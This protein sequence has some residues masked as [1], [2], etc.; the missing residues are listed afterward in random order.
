M[1][2]N[3]KEITPREFKVGDVV[4]DSV[5]FGKGKVVNIDKQSA[6]PVDVVAVNDKHEEIF[7]YTIEGKY[8]SDD[9][10]PSLYHQPYKIELLDIPEELPEVGTPVYVWDDGDKSCTVEF[11]VEKRDKAYITSTR[12][13]IVNDIGSSW[14]NM[15]LILP[16]K[17]K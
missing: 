15:S 5:R 12:F 10:L 4:W 13:P 3:N 14:D 8:R 1:D 6:Y 7:S 2:N 16:D 9:L 17:F 11:F